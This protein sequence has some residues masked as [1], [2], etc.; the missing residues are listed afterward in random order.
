MR[1][2]LNLVDQ[3]Y[4]DGALVSLAQLGVTLIILANL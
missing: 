1:D 2:V 3:D 4:F